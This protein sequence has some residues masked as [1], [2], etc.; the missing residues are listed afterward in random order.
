MKEKVFY[1]YNGIKIF[2]PYNALEK[3]MSRNNLS[4][5]ELQ[6]TLD[7]VTDVVTPYF[8]GID[9]RFCQRDPVY[10]LVF[11]HSIDDCVHLSLHKKRKKVRV[12]SLFPPE[13]GENILT[14]L[15]RF[16][17]RPE[18]VVDDNDIS[19]NTLREDK[20]TSNLIPFKL[21][22]N[23]PQDFCASN[24]VIEFV[25][26][27]F[28]F[29]RKPELDPTVPKDAFYIESAILPVDDDGIDAKIEF[30]FMIYPDMAVLEYLHTSTG[31]CSRHEIS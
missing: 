31:E 4:Q 15:V 19:I 16:T 17:L 24:R 8:T 9:S 13:K 18:L 12:V 20:G 27:H 3:L 7:K 26:R 30:M 1:K 14:P 6:R 29:L 2:N 11:L 23:D 28:M 5:K 21:K 10:C 22:L 25:N